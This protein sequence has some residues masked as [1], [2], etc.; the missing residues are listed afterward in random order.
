MDK[1]FFDRTPQVKVRDERPQHYIKLPFVNEKIKRQIE[2]L[3][4]RCGIRDRMRVIYKSERPLGLRWRKKR[5]CPTCHPRC[6]ACQMTD[7]KNKCCN[8]FA[9][10]ELTCL[11][12]NAVYIGQTARTT[13]SRIR[14]HLS[15]LSSV[16]H[17]HV[18]ASRDS[19]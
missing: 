1:K 3:A 16:F 6:W 11:K 5:E 18:P 4:K 2:N 9:I 14:E 15:S 13:I 12:C 17:R 8:K 10:D 19:R 7:S